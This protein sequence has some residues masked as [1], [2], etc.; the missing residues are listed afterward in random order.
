MTYLTQ[1]Q[2]LIDQVIN[3][4]TWEARALVQPAAEPTG[5]CS[6]VNATQAAEL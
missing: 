2:K 4:L 6:K 3:R 1:K 5:L